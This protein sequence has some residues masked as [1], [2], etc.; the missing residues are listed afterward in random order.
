MSQIQW[1]VNRVREN[2]EP[3][4]LHYLELINK[5]AGELENNQPGSANGLSL[6]FNNNNN[7][8]NSFASA[9]KS[10]FDFFGQFDRFT[11]AAALAQQQHQQQ[12]LHTSGSDQTIENNELDDE[13]EASYDNNVYEDEDEEE[14]DE[15][16]E[17]SGNEANSSSSNQS[18][19]PS[20]SALSATLLK[21]AAGGSSHNNK[22]ATAIQTSTDR[23]KKQSPT[24][25]GVKSLAKSTESESNRTPTF[26]E[27][28]KAFCT[29]KAFLNSKISTIESTLDSLAS[30]ETFVL[31][32]FGEK[33]ELKQQQQQQHR[34][35][36]RK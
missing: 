36:K 5:A 8:N 19:K 28:A 4:P 15:D 1:Y 21:L 34:L 31:E 20:L 22:S 23:P 17:S 3:N 29:I 26:E 11:A 13:E 6:A 10:K 25:T 9:L 35:L 7:N 14:A 2:L 33:R 24:T 27:A 12:L 32:T 18:I 30:A 16:L